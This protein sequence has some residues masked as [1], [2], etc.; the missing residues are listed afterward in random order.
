MPGFVH[1]MR[2]QGQQRSK[3][4]AQSSL[5][6]LLPTG[7]TYPLQVLPKVSRACCEPATLT[8][9][10]VQLVQRLGGVVGAAHVLT[11]RTAPFTVGARMGSGQALA[12]V[13]PGTLQEA[14]DALQAC[15]DADVAVVPQGAN[16][17]NMHDAKDAAPRPRCAASAAHLQATGFCGQG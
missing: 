12:V 17:G 16:T 5:L 13:L 1:L 2:A 4:H 8:E 3:Q 7:S 10:Q 14:V 9:A 11:T 6:T 15:V